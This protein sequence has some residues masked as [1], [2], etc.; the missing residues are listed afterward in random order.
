M[1]SIF[2]YDKILFL[3]MQVMKKFSFKLLCLLFKNVS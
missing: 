1:P 2:C 3:H